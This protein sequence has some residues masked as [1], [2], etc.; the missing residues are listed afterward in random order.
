MSS[1]KRTSFTNTEDLNYELE[2][3]INDE[4]LL[5]RETKLTKS[6]VIKMAIFRYLLVEGHEFNPTFDTMDITPLTIKDRISVGDFLKQQEAK[7]TELDEVIQEQAYSQP[8][9]KV[10]HPIIENQKAENVQPKELRK[11]GINQVV[12]IQSTTNQ[13]KG[14]GI[15]GTLVKILKEHINLTGSQIVTPDDFRAGMAKAGMTSGDKALHHY[16]SLAT[17]FGTIREVGDKTYLI[18]DITMS[19]IDPNYKV[20]SIGAVE[21]DVTTPKTLKRDTELKAYGIIDQHRDPISPLKR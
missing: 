17:K 15:E 2:E 21:T 14:P 19:C 11:E 12:G 1:K 6:S 7:I 9:E 8:V 18:D 16:F 4:N 20:D 3:F 10:D 5:K 13:D